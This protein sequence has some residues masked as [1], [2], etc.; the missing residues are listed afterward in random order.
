[1]N[2]KLALFAL[3]HG[4]R[5]A[6][7]AALLLLALALTA[8]SAIKL[9]YNN[10]PSL[11]HTYLSSAVD[12][13]D[14]QSTQ[15]RRS[16]EN[17]VAWHRNNELTVIAAQLEQATIRLVN[18]PDSQNPITPVELE[19][20]YTTIQGS[21]ARTAL[22]AAPEI[23]K[24]ML[25]LWPNQI[26]Q[27]QRALDE[28]NQEYREQRLQ[29]NP[30]KRLEATAKR[31]EKRFERWLGSLNTTQRA[32]IKQWAEQSQSYS[33]ARYQQRLQ[34]Q[35]EFMRLVTLAANR[36]IEEAALSKQVATLLTA[37]QNPSTA[38]ARQV[39]QARLADTLQLVADVLNTAS[40]Q[41]KQ[42]AAER[43]SG[44]AQDLTVLARG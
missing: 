19:V 13:D 35:E 28:S 17:I 20:Y 6:H 9:G 37:W 18:K 16:L 8:C 7:G 32:R 22:A 33:E 11:A 34:R 31:M 44:W 12:W 24:T 4:R 39:A 5:W 41:Q 42:R 1:M 43:A 30:G 14:K 3:G 27:I 29:S 38:Q 36:Q 25:M 26:Q 2:F 15:L 10:A 21:L 23:A 40:P